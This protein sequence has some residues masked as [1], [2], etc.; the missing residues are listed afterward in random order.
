MQLHPISLAIAALFAAKGRRSRS[1][2]S[3]GALAALVLGYAALANPLKLFGV[4]LLGF[5]LAGS[6]A[7]KFKASIKASYEEPDA[8]A[9]PPSSTSPAKAG[10]GGGN[11]TAA[12][13]ACNALVGCACAVAWRVLYSGESAL[14][15]G[16][17]WEGER[18]CVVERFGEG[19]ARRY[20]RALV[21]AAVAFWGACCGDTFASELGILSLRPP[22]LLTTLRPTPRG[23]NGAVS[24]W[25]TLVSLLGGAL[26]GVLAAGTM[27]LQGQLGACGARGMT[28][29]VVV[30]A[31]AGLGGSAL[32]S[33]LGA[34][35]QPT[36]FSRT[37]KLVVHHPPSASPKDDDVIVLPGTA[38]FGALL[39]NNAVNFLSTAGVVA[40][41]GWWALL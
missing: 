12:Q 28:E 15:A 1:L 18:W 34:L 14:S 11:R 2:S 38:L 16:E 40:V 20:S 23:T 32:D 17:Q 13:V 35:F 22:I 24:P 3:S 8:P 9:P 21:L 26:V 4:A 31:A 19:D 5:Y 37:R 25:G 10:G 27:A 41:A 36:Y 39:S 30:G 7:T 6:R 33:L 29:V